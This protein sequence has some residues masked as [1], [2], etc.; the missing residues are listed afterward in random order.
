MALIHPFMTVLTGVII[1]LYMLINDLINRN[2]TMKHLTLLLIIAIP[3]LPYLIYSLY[4]NTHYPMLLAW[5]RIW[6]DHFQS[7][8]L[9]FNQILIRT[10]WLIVIFMILFVIKWR[11]MRGLSLFVLWI[12][13]SVIAVLLPTHLHFR[14]AEGIGIPIF[15]LIGHFLGKTKRFRKLI[16]FVFA[17]IFTCNTFLLSA[18][19]LFSTSEVCYISE[20]K[21]FI[22]DWIEVNVDYDD[23]I[24]SDLINGNFIP[25]MTGKRVVLGHNYE[26]IDAEYWKEKYDYISRTGDIDALRD[27]EIEYYLC[28]KREPM[29]PEDSLVHIELETENYILYRIIL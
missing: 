20:E 11:S 26:S 2:T 8:N 19:P 12:S 1:G 7:L 28:D 3:S 5:Q 4:A 25:G 14:L 13:I 9:I 22:Y 6:I 23:I 16:V 21:V 24:F 27:N 18:E 17:G 29:K 15:I 10:S